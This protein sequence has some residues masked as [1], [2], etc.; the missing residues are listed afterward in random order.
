MFIKLVYFHTKFPFLKL[1]GFK[2][3]PESNLGLMFYKVSGQRS[4]QDR[5]SLDL[6]QGLV[7]GSGFGSMWF[8]A[9]ICSE[10]SS[11]QT[12]QRPAETTNCR[13]GSGPGPGSYLI[14]FSTLCSLTLMSVRKKNRRK[15]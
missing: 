3:S 7:G 5:T 4:G 9:L 6:D 8:S 13:P 1:K 2:K 14:M 11:D 15:D 10:S 12:Q